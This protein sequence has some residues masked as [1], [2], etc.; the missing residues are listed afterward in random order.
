MASEMTTGQAK[1][2]TVRVGATLETLRG[3]GAVIGE[4]LGVD[5][6][7]LMLTLRLRVGA[8]DL[9]PAHTTMFFNFILGK[10]VAAYGEIDRLRG[11]KDEA[12]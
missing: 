5:R 6:H 12:L 9:D 11:G 2:S 10:L 3:A 4:E 7:G 8:D 1:R